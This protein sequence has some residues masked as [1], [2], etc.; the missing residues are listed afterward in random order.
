[1]IINKGVSLE[2]Y[3]ALVGWGGGVLVNLIMNQPKS[4][5]ATPLS[6]WAINKK[7]KLAETG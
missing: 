1:M 7:K 2:Y 5:Q 3:R 4:S 6:P